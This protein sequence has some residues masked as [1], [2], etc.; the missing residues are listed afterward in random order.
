MDTTKPVRAEK[1]LAATHR[2]D[3]VSGEAIRV[4]VENESPVGIVLRTEILRTFISRL[5][6]H[7]HH[8]RKADAGAA[9]ADLQ[10]QSAQV[11]AAARDRPQS[12]RCGPLVPEAHKASQ[13]R[14]VELTLA[15][16]ARAAWGVPPAESAVRIMGGGGRREMM[17]DH[18]QDNDLVRVGKL[19]PD[20]EAST[21]EGDEGLADRRIAPISHHESAAPVPPPAS[22]GRFLRRVLNTPHACLPAQT[23]GAAEIRGHLRSHATIHGG[24]CALSHQMERSRWHEELDS[25]IDPTR[26]PPPGHTRLGVAI[27]ATKQF[28]VRLQDDYATAIFRR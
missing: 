5:R 20:F 24:T 3:R 12:H 10:G 23:C 19:S 18:D 25:R 15:A 9:L 1:I 2:C 28:H 16:M 11:A 6:I 8:L 13:R 17:L 22:P 27:R 4:V 26:L 14:L 21:H 7:T